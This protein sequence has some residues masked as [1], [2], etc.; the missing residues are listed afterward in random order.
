MKI[1]G[2][3]IDLSKGG[4]QR[5]FVSVMNYFCS[6]GYEVEVVLQNNENSIYEKDLDKNITVNSLSAKSA[7]EAL[8]GLI[9]YTKK[10]HFDC[11]WVFGVEFAI[12]LVI[13]RKISKK[14]FAIC[15]RSINTL[16]N[17]FINTDSFFRKYITNGLA[18]RLY[19]KVDYV[20]AQS[21]NMGNDL[22]EN[23][24]FKKN[25]VYVINNMLSEQFEKE[26]DKEPYSGDRTYYLFAG[27]LEKQKGLHIL[28]D[29]FEKVQDPNKKL[30]I[31][32]DGSLKE[33]L[34]N[35]VRDKGLD[36][37]IEFKGYTKSII[38]FY[39]KAICTV[40]TS[41][42][43]GFPNV[44]IESISCGTPVVSFDLPSGP[45]E[46]IEE[47]INGYL[48]NYMDV[49]AFASALNA[50]NANT[51]D[52]SRIKN[53]ARRYKSLE[54]FEKYRLLQERIEK[55]CDG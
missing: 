27:R 30:I 8:F 5:V 23:Y 49:D 9:K 34:Y 15:A 41:Y 39:K 14:N 3:I 19:H 26:L 4:A 43:E 53:S 7:K 6:I 45:N 32:G 21:I 44:L 31:I 36:G 11:A 35:A 48:V 37:C 42:Y 10:N 33:P 46:I 40:L 12:N 2:M 55:R 20:V 52:Y 25:Q 13:A 54:L 22:V 24:N 47:G 28:I 51:W 16:T 29:A 1:C 18:K 17:E 38:D 50:V